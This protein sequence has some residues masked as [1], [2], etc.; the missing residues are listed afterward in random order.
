MFH[1]ETSCLGVASWRSGS[2]TSACSALYGD[3]PAVP[4]RDLA[5]ELTTEIALLRVIETEMGPHA[6]VREDAYRQVFRELA[7][8]LDKRLGGI[9]ERDLTHKE[10]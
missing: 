5:D 6:A 10:H 8:P 4:F 3:D 7:Y 2:S 9:K 1:R